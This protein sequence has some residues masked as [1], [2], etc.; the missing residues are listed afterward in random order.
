MNVLEQVLNREK[1][2]KKK[3]S[4]QLDICLQHRKDE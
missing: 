4:S 2:P 3:R 1:K